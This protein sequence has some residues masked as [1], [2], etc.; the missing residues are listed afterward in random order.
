[1]W[2]EPTLRLNMVR[3]PGIGQTAPLRKLIWL[4]L[5]LYLDKAAQLVVKIITE[6]DRSVTNVDLLDISR[7]TAPNLRRA[8][9]AAEITE[10]RKAR[11]R[12]VIIIL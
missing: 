6:R 4:T 7:E 3:V 2:E 12:E 9:A 5:L 1:M 8:E 10:I 11:R